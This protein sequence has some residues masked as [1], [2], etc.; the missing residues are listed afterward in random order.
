[1]PAVDILYRGALLPNPDKSDS[2]RLL[3]GAQQLRQGRLVYIDLTLKE[4]VKNTV[5]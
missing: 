2:G 3:V 5:K 1:M 4:N